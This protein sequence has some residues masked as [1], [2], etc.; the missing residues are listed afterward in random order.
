MKASGPNQQAR[1]LTAAE[2]AQCVRMFRDAKRWSQEQLA[3]ISGLSERTIQRVEKGLSGDFNTRRALARAFEFE[4]IDVFNTLHEI[5]SEEEVKA[6]QEKLDKENVTLTATSLTT[7]RQL[8]RLVTS[9]EMD[10]S[11]P[12]LKMTREAEEVF[13][14]LVDYYRDY[15]DCAKLYSE[16]QKI[17]VYDE[18]QSFIDALKGFGVSLIYAERK[19]KMKWGSNPASEPISAKVLYLV[20]FPLGE[21]PKQFATPKSV[22]ISL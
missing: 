22:G 6:A 13:S 7:G 18:M 1:H 17:E 19:V 12:A 21:E 14:E 10:M 11:E 4:D 20:A 16:R 3:E 5:Q 8:A 2:L 15:R 9:C